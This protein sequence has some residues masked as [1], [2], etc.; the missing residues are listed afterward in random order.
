MICTQ[1][2]VDR[3]TIA[4]PSGW[5]NFYC[6]GATRSRWKGTVDCEPVPSIRRLKREKIEGMHCLVN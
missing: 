2:A 3:P 4:G 6:I 1:F 5:L